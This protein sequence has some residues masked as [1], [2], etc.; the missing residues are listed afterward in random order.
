MLQLLFEAAFMLFVVFY[1]LA[2]ATYVIAM[3]VHT[4]RTR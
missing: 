4:I 1:L 2:A 3:I